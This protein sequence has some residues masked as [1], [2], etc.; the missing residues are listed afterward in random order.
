VDGAE[1]DAGW[2]VSTQIT[3]DLFEDCVGP[4]EE[5]T[6]CVSFVR[7]DYSASA[8]PPAPDPSYDA[9]ITAPPEA[10]DALAHCLAYP[11]AFY[12]QGPAGNP[13]VSGSIVITQDNGTWSGSGLAGTMTLLVETQA[14]EWQLGLEAPGGVPLQ[15][16][17]YASAVGLPGGGTSPALGLVVNGVACSVT[18]GDFQVLDY[19]DDG[20]PQ[21]PGLTRL[22]A[23]FDATCQAGGGPLHGCVHYVAQ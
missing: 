20:V 14:E 12:V 15:E 21:T 18:S 16:G 6:G 7:D 11:D 23:T 17:S 4:S 5:L 2:V 13:V 3:F 1:D 22:T 9:G 19:A 8:P 10:G